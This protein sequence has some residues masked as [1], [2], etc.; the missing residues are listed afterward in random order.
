MRHIDALDLYEAAPYALDGRYRYSLDHRGASV[1]GVSWGGG[2]DVRE[3]LVPTVTRPGARV[4]P[5]AVEPVVECRLGSAGD[6]KIRMRLSSDPLELPFPEAGSFAL[7]NEPDELDELEDEDDLAA[8]DRLVV[9][10][11]GGGGGGGGVA[12]TP[13][14]EERQ[15]LAAETRR[16]R[17]DP[18]WLR[19]EYGPKSTHGVTELGG[20]KA[21]GRCRSNKLPCFVQTAPPTYGKRGRARRQCLTCGA[22]PCTFAASDAVLKQTGDVSVV[23]G[24]RQPRHTGKK[25][26]YAKP[27]RAHK[28]P[29][30]VSA[31]QAE[32]P[33][34]ASATATVTARCV[35]MVHKMQRASGG[36]QSGLLYAADPAR[37]T[38]GRIAHSW[39]G[40]VIERYAR[41]AAA[42]AARE[43]DAAHAQ[44]Q[45]QEHAQAQRTAIV[46]SD[47]DD[48]D[49]DNDGDEL[50]RLSPISA[51]ASL[52]GTSTS[53]ASVSLPA[54]ARLA[55]TPAR[56]PPASSQARR[57]VASAAQI[58]PLPFPP[59]TPLASS[60]SAPMALPTA[61]SPSLAVSST[62]LR[63]D[64]PTAHLLVQAKSYA[65]LA[66]AWPNLEPW[67]ADQLASSSASSTSSASATTSSTSSWRPRTPTRS[68]SGPSCC[69]RPARSSTLSKMKGR[70]QHRH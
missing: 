53:A 56:A 25:P 51:A 22:L 55:A 6:T 16:N 40:A 4:A 18:A 5:V 15:R 31:Q 67:Q 36:G 29:A 28:R 38:D 12:G 26:Q 69:L 21:C 48:E 32:A 45:G 11:D 62:V 49:G 17:Q 30:A 57:P 61:R 43:P 33:A 3:A 64:W 8:I 70:G 1:I 20:D 52:P 7:V 34:L 54:L 58:F 23:V 2:A 35:A 42:I 59:M 47:D 10:D 9:R 68:P 27:K 14:R 65:R 46:L 66:G 50:N 19:E 60:A 39:S 63:T 44:D 37:R 41:W 24:P 13:S